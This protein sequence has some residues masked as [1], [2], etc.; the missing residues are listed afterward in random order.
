VQL[1]QS[2]SWLV[3]GLMLAGC[4]H[5]PLATTTAR[6]TGNPHVATAK[7]DA[8]GR[9]MQFEGLVKG[10][11][12]GQVTLTGTVVTLKGTKNA[13]VVYDFV[14]APRTGLVRVTSDGFSTTVSNEKL[15]ETVSASAGTDKL[16][17]AMII[18]IAIDVAIGGAKA[19][20]IYWLTHR[21]DFNRDDAIKAC[22]VGMVSAL[23]DF[24]P[25]GVY[26]EWLVP[27]AVN[28]ISQVKTGDFKEIAAIAMKDVDKVVEVVKKILHAQAQAKVAR[29][30]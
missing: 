15:L 18:P 6:S 28:I 22:V 14:D 21:T 7:L 16:L 8:Q 10:Q 24:V 29:A 19:L 9:A 30:L 13:P 4:S 3:A 25:Y 23:L 2:T 11:F 27:I 5:A 20:A 26:F 1:R 12:L 17:P